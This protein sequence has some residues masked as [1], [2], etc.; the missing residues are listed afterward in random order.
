MAKAAG[1]ATKALTTN[2]RETKTREALICRDDVEREDNVMA[3]T[4][5]AGTEDVVGG[6]VVA[7]ANVVGTDNVVA[8]NVVA[9][10]TWAATNVSTTGVGADTVTKAVTKE[11]GG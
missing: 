5:V 9:A 8:T 4:N 1:A 11:C 10:K 2:E 3:T 6:E 7:T